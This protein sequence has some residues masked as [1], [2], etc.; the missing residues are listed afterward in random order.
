VDHLPLYRIEKQFARLGIYLPRS[1]MCDWL[2]S[3]A[4]KLHPIIEAMRAII[5][6][7]PRIWTDDTTL[8]LQNDDPLRNTV[9]QARLWVYIGGPL[10]D[11]PL[12][13]YDYTRTRSQQGP[14]AFLES[15][16]GF[17]QA[18]AYS[19]YQGLYESG[20][21]IE[22][23]CWSHCRRKF[24]EASIATKGNTR[25]HTALL[26]IRRLYQVE[27]SCKDLKDEQRK[28]HRMEHAKPILDTFKAWAD[29]QIDAVLP[30]SPLGKALFYMLNHWE[31]LNRYLDEGFLKPDNNKAEQ[32]IR[33]VALGRKNFLFVGSDR[34]GKAAGGRVST[35]DT[36]QFVEK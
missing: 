20:D 11:P 30:K 24:Y 15:Y 12:V 32:H 31:S 36:E 1:T 34:G 28:A 9:K 22:V 16:E 13:L 5:L 33:P 4:E 25:A 10:K 21:I 27:W 14:Q 7:G 19:G 35:I 6:S 23:A 18:D 17:L 29:Q 26:Q 2:M 8:P 3:V